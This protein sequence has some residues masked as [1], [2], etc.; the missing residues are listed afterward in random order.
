MFEM[1]NKIKEG[2]LDVLFPAVCAG[3]RKE[4]RYICERCSVFAGEAPLI[5]PVCFRASFGG[6]RHSLC[7]SRYGLDGLVNMWEFEGV[8]KNLIGK[9]KYYGITHA[10][11]EIGKAAFGV[12]ARDEKRFYAF[13]SFLLA[14]DTYI[15]YIPMFE[16]KERHKGFN[17][18]EKVA[19]E[20]GKISG[21]SVVSLLEKVRDTRSQTELDKT[22]RMEN[23]RD[24][25]RTSQKIHNS[26]LAVL[27]IDDIW[28]TGATMRECCKVLKK[29]GVQKVWG[30]T[31]ARTV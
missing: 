10:V 19:Q 21:R 15:A 26:H 30:F 24:S 5:C 23:V 31:L 27:L 12:M 9:I 17:H 4:G 29:A 1:V 22:E 16:K 18:A 2:V 7:K 14:K 28:T 6:E 3:C 25:F 8:I 20:I 11:A 13:L